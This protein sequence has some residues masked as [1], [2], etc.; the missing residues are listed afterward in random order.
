[1]NPSIVRCALATV[2][3]A[4]AFVIYVYRKIIYEKKKESK[5][6]GPQ[7]KHTKLYPV[8]GGGEK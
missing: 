7:N 3:R 8:H 5:M 1:M 2:P 4:R 6:R